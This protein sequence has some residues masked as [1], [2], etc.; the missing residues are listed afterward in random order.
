M[1][2]TQDVTFTVDKKVIDPST[3]TPVDNITQNDH[4]YGSGSTMT[5]QIIVQN[6]G[7]NAISGLSVNDKLP[8]ELT[9]ISGG[10]GYDQT[11]R[12]MTQT[13][14]LQPG[15]TQ[16]ITLSARTSTDS[17]MIPVKCVTNS[18]TASTQALEAQDQAQAC[19]S[20]SVLGAS[21]TTTK[22]GLTITPTNPITKYPGTGPEHVAL[23]ALLPL[24]WLGSKL[25]AYK[26]KKS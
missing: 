26:L 2:C 21:S 10:Q 17:G 7:Q 20:S 12:I 23:L 25:H 18:V 14:N 5:F 15:E 3:Q 1:D 4:L 24:G 19:Y 9:Y 13:L 16:T 22:G 11:T 8:S 6:T